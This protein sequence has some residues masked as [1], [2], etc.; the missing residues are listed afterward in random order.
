MMKLVDILY[1]N[2]PANQGYVEK[3][4]PKLTEYYR[5]LYKGLDWFRAAHTMMT[6]Q[7]GPYEYRAA[8]MNINIQIETLNKLTSNL[9]NT[10]N[11]DM[12][13]IIKL[14]DELLG[15]TKSLNDNLILL[16][17]LRDMF[18]STGQGSFMDTYSIPPGIMIELWEKWKKEIYEPE[19]EKRKMSM[20]GKQLTYM[21]TMGDDIHEYD[22]Q[23]FNP[24]FGLKDDWKIYHHHAEDN[25]YVT[26]THLGGGGEIWGS[27]TVGYHDRGLMFIGKDMNEVKEFIDNS[28]MN[29]A[30]SDIREYF[31]NGGDARKV[32]NYI[33]SKAGGTYPYEDVDIDDSI[34]FDIEKYIDDHPEISFNT[35]GETSRTFNYIGQILNEYLNYG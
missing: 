19:I 29:D 12:G 17:H 32:I 9:Q 35:D 22:W 23:S 5:G 26:N 7:R 21:D 8:A 20:G 10:L 11:M 15:I 2:T 14:K 4:M 3:L 31:D 30:I 13:Q 28:S 24:V 6:T 33:R 1:E 18:S 27:D 25:I 16:V 34:G